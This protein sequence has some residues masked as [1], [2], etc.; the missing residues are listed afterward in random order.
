MT[1]LTL[2]A[3]KH[4]Y[5][6]YGE[7]SGFFQFEIIISV[8]VGYFRFIWILI[9]MYQLQTHNICKQS[10]SGIENL[11]VPLIKKYMYKSGTKLGFDKFTSCPGLV[12]SLI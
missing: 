4:F 9:F 10:K 12:E 7:R 3:L 2:K 1:S 5:G 6:S 8:L 11:L